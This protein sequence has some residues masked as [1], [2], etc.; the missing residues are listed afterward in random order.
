M[1]DPGA[2]CGCE[3]S[4]R[5]REERDRLAAGSWAKADIRREALEEAA[6]ICNRL[7]AA[8]RRSYR[9][10]EGDELAIAATTIRAL[11]DAPPAEEP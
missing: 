2:P 5:L 9:A 3:E 6:L 1:S 7:E 4:V 10:S 11:I 8:A